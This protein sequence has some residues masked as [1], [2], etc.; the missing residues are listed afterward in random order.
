MKDGSHVSISVEVPWHPQRCTNCSLFSHS[1]NTCQRKATTITKAWVPK[2]VKSAE[3]KEIEDRKQK[4]VES[5][6]K[7]SDTQ[8]SSEA[9]S[10]CT[11]EKQKS[12]KREVVKVEEKQGIS[13][14]NGKAKSV[15]R[16][17]ILNAVDDEESI[18]QFPP[19]EINTENTQR[20]TRAASAGVAELMKTFKAKKKGLV[21][22]GRVQQGNKLL[23]LTMLL[24]V[25]YLLVN[26]K[27]NPCKKTDRVL[28]NDCWEATTRVELLA[29]EVSDHCPALIQLE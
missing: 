18:E 2:Q 27:K 3:V 28:I 17:S 26:T 15:N 22:K 11:K 20:K 5:N 4:M 25:P 14:S 16:F 23:F 24:L 6:E 8:R 10:S 13:S 12:K 21:D 1:P 19:L 9:A 29:P 7:I